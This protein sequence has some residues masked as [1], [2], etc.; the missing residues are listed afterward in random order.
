MNIKVRKVC[1]LIRRLN[2]TEVK[3]LTES[4]RNLD[5][6]KERGRVRAKPKNPP[7]KL[8]GGAEVAIPTDKAELV[9]AISN[10]S[11]GG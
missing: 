6:P 1:D 4:L 10:S 5:F 7:G 8:S 9:E 2:V 11:R 3:E